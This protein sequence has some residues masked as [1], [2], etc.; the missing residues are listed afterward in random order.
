MR[1]DWSHEYFD[2][3]QDAYINWLNEQNDRFTT[4]NGNYV[5]DF[6]RELTR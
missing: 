6:H 5:V 2:Q 3:K 1:L 4:R